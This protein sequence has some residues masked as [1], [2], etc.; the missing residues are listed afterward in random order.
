MGT[1]AEGGGG[2][3]GAVNVD[4]LYPK[5]EPLFKMFGLVI[6]RENLGFKFSEEGGP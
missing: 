3:G 2:G 1:D 5:G 4:G 6:A